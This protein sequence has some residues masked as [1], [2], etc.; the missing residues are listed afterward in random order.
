GDEKGCARRLDTRASTQVAF[1]CSTSRLVQRNELILPKLCR[2]DQKSVGCEVVDLQRQGLRDAQAR[3][4]QQRQERGVSVRSDGAWR[5]ESG[6]G[7]PYRGNLLA[8]VQMRRASLEP[9][10][11]EHIG[12][13]HLMAW[14]F[15]AHRECEAP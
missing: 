6:G 10:A 14:V 9:C 5:R 1:Q 8:A 13:W 15:C 11:T 7:L 4:G 12:R 2:A 3:S